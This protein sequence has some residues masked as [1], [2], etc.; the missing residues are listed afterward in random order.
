MD[1][2]HTICNAITKA[3]NK[4]KELKKLLE[5]KLNE[6][7]AVCKHEYIRVNTCGHDHTYYE[8]KVCGSDINEL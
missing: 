7:K 1:E 5:I 8:C 6:F 3:E 4:V 2:I